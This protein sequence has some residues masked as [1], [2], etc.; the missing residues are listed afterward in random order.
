MYPDGTQHQ[1]RIN[2]KFTTVTPSD[3]FLSLL[4]IPIKYWN[5]AHWYSLRSFEDLSFKF[6]KESGTIWKQWIYLIKEQLKS[7]QVRLSNTFFS[8]YYLHVCCFHLKF[9][10]RYV[11][12]L[13]LDKIDS[14]VTFLAGSSIIQLKN[15]KYFMF[16]SFSFVLIDLINVVILIW[17]DLTSKDSVPSKIAEMKTFKSKM[18]NLRIL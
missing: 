5:L 9:F 12:R 13:S 7:E 3:F 2:M 4:F 8:E 10:S 17:Q 6:F 15:I 14:P 16:S 18:K 11:L 1:N